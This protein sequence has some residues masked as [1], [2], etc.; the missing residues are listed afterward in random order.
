LIYGFQPDIANGSESRPFRH[1]LN[2]FVMHVGHTPDT[3]EG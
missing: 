2:G 1:G 3:N